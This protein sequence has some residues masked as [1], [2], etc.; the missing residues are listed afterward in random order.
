MKS[1]YRALD[2]SE[3]NDI[4]RKFSLI[5]EAEVSEEVRQQLRMPTFDSWQWTHE[6]ML[7]LLQQMFIDL[8]LM[9]RFALEV[10]TLRRF[11]LRVFENYNVVPFH[12]FRHGFCVT[13]M[14]Y[15]MVW[16]CDLMSRTE[17]LDVF[18]LL[19]A[20]ICHD[21]D[22]PGYN[23]IYQINAGTDLAL[24]YNDVSPLENHHCSV[25]FSILH[26]P[27]SNLL[28]GLDGEDQ[29]RARDG[30]IRCI[31]ATDMARHNEII[32]Q[33]REVLDEFDF[34]E[35]VHVNLLSMVLIKIA[36][37]SNEAR[38][39]PVADPWIDCLLQE[40]YNQSDR[41]KEEGLPVTPFMDREKVNKAA[42][43]CNFISFVLMPLFT[44]AA[45]LLKELEGLV[46]EPARQALEH[47]SRLNDASRSARA[48]P[49]GEPRRGS[50]EALNEAEV[51]E[52]SAKFKIAT[53]TDSMCRRVSEDCAAVAAAV[54]PAAG[55]PGD[56][57]TMRFSRYF[58]WMTARPADKHPGEARLANG[59]SV[60]SS[61]ARQPKPGYLR[62][63]VL[64]KREHLVGGRKDTS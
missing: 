19:I 47:Y 41:E 11:L 50:E 10:S 37:I 46:L 9:T 42:S 43:Q 55:S 38:P 5:R 30:I 56:G 28:A 53:R 51:S 2:E 54:A 61:P 3:L 1:R 32:D 60:R 57:Q 62:S 45:E 6:E 48:S 39:V 35:P 4:M 21:L 33:F 29:R 22:H 20:C 59:R 31:L 44:A 15:S 52:R 34:G 64:R 12:N 18:I 16:A 63:L 40:F 58:R 24:R 49:A 8:E 17:P 13:Q 26:E 23:N 36:D 25:A 7:L 27:D 14:M